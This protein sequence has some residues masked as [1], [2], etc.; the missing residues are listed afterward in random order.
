MSERR[1]YGISGKKNVFLLFAM[2]CSMV[3]V[4]AGCGNTPDA[5]EKNKN[6]VLQDRNTDISP[7]LVCQESME[8]EYADQFAV[9][10]YEGGY[11]LIS[12]T[13][14]RRYLAVPEG[15]STPEKLEKDIIVLKRPVKDVYLVATAVMDM[16]CELDALDSIRFSG[17]KADGWSRIEA[18]EAMERG[19]IFYAGKY[20]AP[21]YETIVS[22]GC[23]HAIEN[24]MIT[25][26]P[27]VVEKLGE[28]GIPVLIDLSSY[29]SHPLGRAE[30]I[31]MYGVLLGKEEEAEEVFDRQAQILKEVSAGEPSG[32]TAA[33][34]FITAN[35]MVNV[36][37]SSDYVP[38]MIE[39]AGGKYIFEDLE[40][41]DSHRS[42]VAMQMEEF[43]LTAK[44]ADY[45]IYN[46]TIEGGVSSV[47]ELLEMESLLGDFKAVKE[48][49]VWC[50]TRDL[51]QQSMSIGQMIGDF[52]YMLSGEPKQQENI[53][54]MYHL[55]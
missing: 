13:D 18:R 45:L 36:R 32:K 23:S 11:A 16:F 27:E 39:L 6:K 40:R 30:W 43:Y 5:D 51:Y 24:N 20:S 31:R 34:F 38:R 55:E 12:M 54:Y 53:R 26:S 46:S 2:I 25:H 42:S 8:L 7:H 1:K 41:E 22:R 35:G 10:Y 14:G 21:D 52:H 29:E 37:V 48:G 47:Q 4:L 9:D 17:Q 50:T 33:Y 19:E 3:F 28:F 15:K 49:N 44:D